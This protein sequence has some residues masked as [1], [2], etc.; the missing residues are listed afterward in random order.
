ML[1]SPG[2]KT[3]KHKEW[4]TTETWTLITERKRL[5]DQINQT[6][7]QE[8]KQELQ[9]HYWDKNQEVKRSAKK[10]KRSFIEELTQEAETTVNQRNMKRLYDI[11]QGPS[12][13]KTANLVAQSKTRTAIPFQ[14]R[15]TREQNGQNTSRKHSTDLHH[16]LH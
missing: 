4:L 3:R 16:V 13:E 15:K 2:K 5:K 11:T 10:D 8:E 9:A 6:Q 7:V 1:N 14:G 12:L